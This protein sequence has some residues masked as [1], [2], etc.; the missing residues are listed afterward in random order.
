MRRVLTSVRARTVVPAAALTLALAATPAWPAT[1][2]SLKVSP[3]PVR[4]GNSLRVHGRAAGCPRGNIVT[5]I[6]RAF[7]GPK[8]FAGVPAV[9]TKVR[10]HGAFST[11]AIV[12]RVRRPG[13]YRVS[14]RCGGG[15]L[16]VSVR[17][18]VTA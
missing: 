8:E 2:A 1:R 17:L 5:I 6:S 10:A 18:R 12:P 15:N 4:S 14:A 3:N 9:T 16:G 13:H 11:T 7:G